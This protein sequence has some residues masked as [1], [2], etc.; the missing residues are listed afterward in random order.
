MSIR[1]LTEM[2]LKGLAGRSGQFQNHDRR[3]IASYSN[4]HGLLLTIS[5]KF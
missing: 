2:F 3:K 5:L 1:L 4:A